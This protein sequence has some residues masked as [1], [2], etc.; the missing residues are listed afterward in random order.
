MMSGRGFYRW[1][2]FLPILAP[3]ALLAF[4]LTGGRHGPLLGGTI[5]FLGFSL[6]F[7]GIPYGLLALWLARWMRG[8]TENEIRRVSYLAPILMLPIFWGCLFMYEIVAS[9]PHADAQHLSGGALLS[10]FVLLLGYAY[11]LLVNGLL[12]LLKKGGVVRN[13]S[14]QTV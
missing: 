1:S 12:M 5:E 7:G 13:D 10:P 11:V 4:E 3:A 6:V 9:W 2:L 8:K 14:Q